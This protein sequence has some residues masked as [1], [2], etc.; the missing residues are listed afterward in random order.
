MPH[1]AILAAALHFPRWLEAMNCG[2]APFVVIPG[3]HW[4]KE[5]AGVSY[6]NVI[7]AMT[8][9]HG[10]GDQAVL[11]T[12][13]SLQFEPGTMQGGQHIAVPEWC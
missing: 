9:S 10:S 2:K 12:C 8:V 7:R 13:V 6:F 3:I 5:D 4:R 11:R 1:M